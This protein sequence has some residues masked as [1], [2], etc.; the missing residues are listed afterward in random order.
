MKEIWNQLVCDF[1][2]RQYH[3][4]FKS[5]VH[6]VGEAYNCQ[7]TVTA[8]AS[9][10]GMILNPRFVSAIRH[11]LIPL[12]F[13]GNFLI[14]KFGIEF[15]VGTSGDGGGT[16][17]GRRGTRKIEENTHKSLFSSRFFVII[18]KSN[19]F[20]VM[21]RWSGLPSRKHVNANGIFLNTLKRWKCK[22]HCVRSAAWFSLPN[23]PKLPIVICVLGNLLKFMSLH[24]KHL[25]SF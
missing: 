23:R 17:G 4:R 13:F 14:L 6:K 15:P 25:K 11:D 18:R 5:K 8:L 21:T 1:W 12:P 19:C 9:S 22:N 7:N 24:V 20:V 10:V 3:D 16:R 2:S